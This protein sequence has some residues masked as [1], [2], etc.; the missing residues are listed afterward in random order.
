MNIYK[1]HSEPKTLE[2]YENRLTIVPELAYNHAIE[3][4][5][6]FEAGEPSIMNHPNWA[7]WYASDV[8]EGRWPEAESVIMNDPGYAY[9]YALDIIKGRWPE[10]EPSIMKSPTWAYLYAIKLIKCRWP[11]AEPY[12]MKDPHCWNNYQIMLGW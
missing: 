2:Q 7:F 11:E 8:I 9:R 3:T 12:I 1:Y 10:A 4:N 6:R 5:Q